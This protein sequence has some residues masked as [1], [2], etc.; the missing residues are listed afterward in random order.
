LAD[1]TVIYLSA[2]RLPQRMADFVR[3][4]LLAAIGRTPLISM[5][6]EPLDFGQNILQVGPWCASTIYS[7]MLRAAKVAVTPFVAVA[8]DDTLYP[9]EHFTWRPPAGAFLYDQNRFS[10]FTWGEPLYN[11]RN[12]RSNSTLIAYRS[13]LVDALEERFQKWPNGTPEAQTG[14]I[15]RPMVERNLGLTPQT[16]VEVFSTVSTI[17]I[18]H[19][20][21]T[22][23]RERRQRKSHGPIRAYDI[24]HW[25]RADRLLEQF[26]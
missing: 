21:G 17:N 14:E 8:E 25:G 5:T 19:S 23:D 16:A 13:L 20:Y 11:W 7:E 26:Q 3:G 18:G 15:G 24:P 2:S 10:L 22:N 1:L 6:R 9:R 12:R 4:V